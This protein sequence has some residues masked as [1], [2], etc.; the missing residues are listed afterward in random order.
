MKKD[1]YQ[2]KCT[3]EGSPT[4]SEIHWV[5]NS[6]YSNNELYNLLGIEKGDIYNNTVL[7]TRLLGSPDSRD[8]HSKYLDNGY[9]FSQVTPVETE[10]RN[11]TID[12]EVRI[13][14]GQQARLTK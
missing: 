1:I 9:L 8:V 11:D 4:I 6:K 12:L 2:L 5:G 7:Q 14:E 13:Y 10:I 3:L